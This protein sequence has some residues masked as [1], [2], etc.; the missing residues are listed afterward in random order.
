LH[1]NSWSGI[2]PQTSFITEKHINGITDVENGH[3][4]DIGDAGD[5]EE[6][7]RKDYKSACLISDAIF[8]SFVIQFL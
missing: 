3:G 7:K 1:C 8:F 2:K 4:S 6:E 5:E